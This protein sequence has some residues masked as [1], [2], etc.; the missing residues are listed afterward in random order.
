[1]HSAD[2]QLGRLV[3]VTVSVH[4]KQIQAAISQRAGD[5]A[6]DASRRARIEAALAGIHHYH[7]VPCKCGNTIRMLSTMACV[8]CHAKLHLAYMRRARQRKIED[9][10]ENQT[11]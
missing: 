10:N 7:G 9:L 8:H 3:I 4:T 11:H 2:M 1:M 5:T 6:K